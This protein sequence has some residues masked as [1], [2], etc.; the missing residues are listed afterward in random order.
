MPGA[1]LWLSLLALLMPVAASTDAAANGPPAPC[2]AGLAEGAATPGQ[3]PQET[4]PQPRLVIIIDDIGNNL[5]Q[6][7]AIVELPGKLN[8]A[9]LPHTPHGASLAEHA[10]RRGKEVLLHAPMSA[11]DGKPPGTGMLTPTMDEP[12]LRET[13]AAA[14]AS[15]P[16]VRGVN[17]HMGSEMTADA[18]S[19]RWLMTL[20]REQGLYFVD[21]RTH[22]STVAAR[23]AQAAGLPHLSRQ[24]FLDNQRE[25]D[26]ILERLEAAVARAREEGLGVAIG[27][28]YPETAAVLRD[29]LPFLTQH[30]VSLALVSE[31]LGIGAA[32]PAGTPA[33]LPEMPRR[34]PLPLPA[35]V[36]D[37]TCL[38]TPAPRPPLRPLCTPS[39]QVFPPGQ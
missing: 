25:P 34:G 7:R 35:D 13:L 2:A 31:A 26:A 37:D 36:P 33:A 19:M 1:F 27:H 17:N 30:G 12:Q 20:L 28:P 9:V 11:R 3:T 18:Q 38:P 29:Q 22:K 10:H 21:S 24:V 32:G 5:E 6:G 15:V 8:I 4:A 39:W 14:L 16:H 23:Q